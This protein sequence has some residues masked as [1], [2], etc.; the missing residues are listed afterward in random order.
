VEESA[1][2]AI[3]VREHV[4]PDAGNA[5]LY[6]RQYQVYRQLYPAV[7]ELAHRLGAV[8]ES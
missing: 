7:R 4:S 6:T 5:R 8:G 2:E 1:R 3:Q